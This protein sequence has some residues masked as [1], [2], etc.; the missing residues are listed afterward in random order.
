MIRIGSRLTI[1]LPGALLLRAKVPPVALNNAPPS[2]ISVVTT[3]EAPGAWPNYTTVRKIQSQ[4]GDAHP[5]GSVG[6]AADLS[7]P[8]RGSTATSWR[9][10]AAAPWCCAS[11]ESWRC[12]EQR[13]TS[14]WCCTRCRPARSF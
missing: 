8:S 1:Q 10:R 14:R 9:S 3:D 5:N 2:T 4:P 7:A 11:G 6:M 13:T 12:R